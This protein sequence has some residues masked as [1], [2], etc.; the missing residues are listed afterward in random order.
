MRTDR[1][2]NLMILQAEDTGRSQ[3]CYGNPVANTPAIDQLASE[4]VRYTHAFSTAP[5][6]APSR[7]AMVTGQAAWTTGAHHM[8]ST[9]Q[10]PPPVFTE[11]LRQAGYYVN[12]AH[13]TDF[14]FD[15]PDTFADEQSDWI[16]ELAQGKFTGK[17]WC[18]YMNFF[19]TH[20]SGM[21]TERHLHEILPRLPPGT[22]CDPATV[23]VPPYLADTPEVRADLASH[24]DCLTLQDREIARAL[25]ALDASG[26]RDHT[27]VIYLSDHGR[28]QIR[29]KRW[30]YDAGIHMPLILRW[31]GTLPEN[32]VDDQIVSWLDI[33]PTL[34]AAAGVPIPAPYQGRVFAGPDVTTPPRTCALAGRDRMDE[35][36]DRIRVLR[37]R[38]FLYIRN[39]HPEIPYAQRIRYMERQRTTRIMRER[40]ASD[41]LT[42]A[43]ALWFATE[44]P[45]EE[46]Y[47]CPSDPHNVHNLANDPAHQD[48][49]TAC[50]NQL[51]Q[52]LAKTGDLGETPEPVLVRQGLV[53]NRIPE[54]QARIRPLPR[55]WQL[56]VSVP[57]PDGTPSAPTPL[58]EIEPT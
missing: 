21:W 16:A 44:K 31:P 3:G 58:T 14:N 9:I 56:P 29:E 30:C 15:P 18:L 46:L 39:F 40:W 19:D 26:E 24:I 51:L 35:A 49:L 1:P 25:A 17:P 33:A 48:T 27:L 41:Q 10:Q 53:A 42:P 23:D 50:R 52:E 7:S 12:W 20:E 47:H 5:V 37:T 57:A 13:K 2:L 6:S 22:R 8:R 28:G 11:S 38:D 43:Q 4:G 55:R 32:H 34:L 54:Y 36:Y 45:T